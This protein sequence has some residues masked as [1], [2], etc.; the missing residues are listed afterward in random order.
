MKIGSI[1]LLPRDQL[2]KETVLRYQRFIFAVF[3]DFPTIYYNNAVALP[4]GRQPVRD[5]DTGAFEF[6]QRVRDLFLCQVVER[7]GR[8]VKKQDFRF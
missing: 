3:N 1:R 7:G 5:H 2:R 4:N 6:S 8:F